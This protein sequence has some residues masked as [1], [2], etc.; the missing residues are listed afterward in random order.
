LKQGK[1]LTLKA[2]Q[3]GILMEQ[4]MRWSGNASLTLGAA[5]SATVG[6]MATLASNG[7]PN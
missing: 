7:R 3:G 1:S 4:T 6:P 5:R 2:S